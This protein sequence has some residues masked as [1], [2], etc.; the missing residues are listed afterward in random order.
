LENSILHLKRTQSELVSFLQEDPEAD[1]DGEMAKAKEENDT[2]M[3][4]LSPSL[5]SWC[6]PHDQLTMQCE[7]T[8]ADHLDQDRSHEQDRRGRDETLWTRRER[9]TDNRFEALVDTGQ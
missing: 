5:A 9:H 3:H 2:V 6:L 1:D 8:G 7:P 4:A